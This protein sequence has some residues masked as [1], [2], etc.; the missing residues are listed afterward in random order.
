MTIYNV[1]MCV[2]VVMSLMNGYK[3]DK[4]INNYQKELKLKKKLI[5]RLESSLN[6]C[7]QGM[8]TFTNCNK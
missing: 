7:E 1:I 5:I 4:I 2:A 3:K 8:E 6:E